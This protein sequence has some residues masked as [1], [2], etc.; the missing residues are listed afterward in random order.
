M[1][2]WK[3]SALLIALAML[4]PFR[5]TARLVP[6]QIQLPEPF[7]TM[8]NTWIVEDEENEAV[9][10]E[11]EEDDENKPQQVEE[12]FQADPD[13]R[14]IRNIKRSQHSER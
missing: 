12:A 14:L 4:D 8:W 13:V 10:A 3:T 2:G 9:Q 7:R 11:K 5:S 6:L 1:F